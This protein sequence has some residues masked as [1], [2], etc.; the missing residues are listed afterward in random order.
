MSKKIFE[1]KEI[2]SIC[3]LI[4]SFLSTFLFSFLL[5]ISVVI[6]EILISAMVGIAFSYFEYFREKKKRKEKDK[7]V[8][9]DD[10]S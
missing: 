10:I 8:D 1:K 7:E 6:Y 4:L 5:N 3:I 2:F 9:I